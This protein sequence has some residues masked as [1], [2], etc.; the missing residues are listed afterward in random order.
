[1]RRSNRILRITLLISLYLQ[2]QLCSAAHVEVKLKS[3]SALE[4]NLLA[5]KRDQLVLDVG[6]TVLLIPRSEI[7]RVKKG[8]LERDL[9]SEIPKTDFDQPCTGQDSI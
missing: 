1:M 4:G 5:E 3:G 8:P 9:N 7:E 6:Y 2:W